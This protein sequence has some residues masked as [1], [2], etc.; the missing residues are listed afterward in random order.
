M[1]QQIGTIFDDI[2]WSVTATAISRV[3]YDNFTRE[4][5][6]DS[7]PKTYYLFHQ[8]QSVESKSFRIET[9]YV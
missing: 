9:V 4:N 2:Y 7:S 5:N 6:A 3:F 1:T 8:I